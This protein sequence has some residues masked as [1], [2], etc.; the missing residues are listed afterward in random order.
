L[1]N[2][3]CSLIIGLAVSYAFGLRVNLRVLSEYIPYLV[4]ALGFGKHYVLTK[5]VFQTSEHQ[6]VKDRVMEGSSKVAC[7]IITDYTLEIAVFG[8][9]ALIGISGLREFCFLSTIILMVDCIFLFTTY[10]SVLS[11]KLEVS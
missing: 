2:G 10:L 3:A 7:M 1:A 11:L 8:S 4:I 6:D 5:A 9:A